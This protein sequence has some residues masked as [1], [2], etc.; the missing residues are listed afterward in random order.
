MDIQKIDFNYRAQKDSI[1]AL[2]NFD[3]V[4]IGHLAL[5]QRVVQRSKELNIRSSVLLFTEH[6]DNFIYYEKKKIITSNELKLQVLKQQGIDIVYIIDF[7]KDF[8]EFSPIDFLKIFLKDHLKIKGIVVGYDYSYGYRGKGNVDFLLK[9]SN[10]FQVID[11]IDAVK[12]QKGIISSTRIRK[13]IQEGNMKDVKRLLKRP[14]C[15]SGT[16]IH[17]KNLGTKMGY[18]TANIE[19]DANYVIPRYG[20][21]DS[22]I[23]IDGQRYCAATNVGKNPTV[24]KNE[25]IK[26]EAHILDF[27]RDIY[28][29]KVYLEFIDFLRPETIF[30]NLEELFGQIN[31]DT[32][33]VC[34]R[35][36]LQL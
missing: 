17:G 26:I 15:I 27:K 34:Q 20:V 3:G 35:K 1:I 25:G 31:L 24:E 4:H 13:L 28:G 7:T 8:M 36:D 16:V 21:Y 18:P 23:I 6:T 12:D 11:V 19:L 9:N 2:G 32:A 14:Y 33:K 10:L 30:K 5:L 22:N 29:K